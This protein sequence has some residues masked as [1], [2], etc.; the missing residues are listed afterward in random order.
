MTDR[1]E[2]EEGWST[3]LLLVSL[4]FIAGY[5]I[6]QSDF[7]DGLQVLPVLGVAAVFTGLLAAKSKF[8]PRVAHLFAA[9]IG[10]F[11]IIYIVGAVLPDDLTW[12]ERI[13]EVVQQQVVF[14]EKLFGGGTNREG[15]VFVTHAGLGIW[16]AGYSAAWYTFRQPKVWRAILPAGLILLS[17]VY[18]YAGPKPM[19]FYMALY[20]LLSLLFVARTHLAEEESGWRRAAVRYD[21]YIT[22]NF[23][24][25]GFIAAIVALMLSWSL[26]TLSA[27]TIVGDALSDTRTPWRRFQD[28]WTRMYSALRTYGQTT[29]DPYQDSLVLGGPRTVSDTPVMDVFVARELPYVYWQTMVYDSYED[30]LWST[31]P[32]REELH[33]TDEGMID[34]PTSVGRQVITQTVVN[35]QPNSSLL[36]GAPEIIGANRDMFVQ[37]RPNEDGEALVTAVRSRYILKQGDFY[38]ITSNYSVADAFSLRSASTNYPEWVTETYLDVPDSVTPET[39][40]LA[41]QITSQY[42]TN[43]DKAIAVRNYLRETITYNDQIDAAPADI[44]PVHYVLF[45]NQEGYCNYYAS[46]MALM[47]R[48]Q[49]IPTRVVSGYAQGQFQQDDNFYRVRQSNAHTWVEVYF[50]EYGWIQFEPTAAI[51]IVERPENSDGG[52]GDAF[53]SFN[54]NIE[55]L[56]PQDLLDEQGFTPGDTNGGLIEDQPPVESG[57]AAGLTSTLLERVSIWQIIAGVVLILAS[58]GLSFLTSRINYQ[59]E[60]DLNKSYGRLERWGRRIGLLIQPAQTPYERA[61]V[62]VTAVPESEQPVRN[63]TNQFVEK[64]FSPSKQAQPTFNSV[65]EWKQLRPV[66]LRTM[67]GHSLKRLGNRIAFWQR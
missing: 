29:V 7:F 48:S 12:R 45:V 21:K 8:S 66:M 15:F 9:V 37:S 16:L 49:G 57:A 60:S 41:E 61:D 65:G 42:D 43:F 51:P 40:A 53:D 55:E 44:D 22:F 1:F 17:V 4:I 54:N 2:I 36:Y 47:L 59:I 33:I 10:A 50:A 13:I 20:I 31:T 63:L 11:T 62:L 35:Y 27:S 30:G 18:Y 19:L 58:V 23:L 38:D 3:L 52:G 32:S 67:L 14:L 39:I 5:G 26:P 56:D 6:S 24:R 28:N 34:I 64:Q 25:A 46:A